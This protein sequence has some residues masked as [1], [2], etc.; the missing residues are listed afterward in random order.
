MANRVR[1]SFL[2][3][4]LEDQ[5]V[6]HPLVSLQIDHARYVGSDYVR[7][8]VDFKFVNAAIVAWCLGDYLVCTH[9]VHQ[10]VETFGTLSQYPFDP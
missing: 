2:A 7:D 5:Y 4:I 1:A 8:F 10:I 6:A 9:A 3:V